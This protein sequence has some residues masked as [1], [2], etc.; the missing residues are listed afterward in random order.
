MKKKKGGADFISVFIL[1]S[2]SIPVNSLELEGTRGT[3]FTTK[4]GNGNSQRQKQPENR[5]S[6]CP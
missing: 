1:S 4:P 5:I 2:L 3:D 6:G